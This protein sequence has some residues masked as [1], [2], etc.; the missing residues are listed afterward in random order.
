MGPLQVTSDQQVERLVGAAQL[1][2]GA[3]RHRIIGLGD[4]VQE[5]VKT[6]RALG[7]VAR[8]E[9][10]ALEHPGDREARR[11]A[12]DV[13]E[14]Q[15]REP[16]RVEFDARPRHV[17]DL[18]ELRAVGVRVRAN[19]VAGERLARLRP[20]RGV[21]DHAGEIADDH[22]HLMAQLLEIAQFGQH[23]GVPQVQVG[24]RRVEAQLDLQRRPGA[25]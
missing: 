22:D 8:G 12:D 2:V 5:L 20:P 18:A 24:R 14:G 21:T 17:D 15:G 13:F 4:R 3:Q 1:H 23:D 11:F 25:A 7:S 10:F 16:R 19:L 9:V 6:D